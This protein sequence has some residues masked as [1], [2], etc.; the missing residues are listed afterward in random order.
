M[1]LDYLGVRLNAEKADNAK[2]LINVDLSND[3]TYFL[4]LENGC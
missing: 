1:F 2:D 4:E 3:G